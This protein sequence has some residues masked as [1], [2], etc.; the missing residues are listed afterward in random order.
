[1]ASLKYRER[2][3][4]VGFLGS[5]DCIAESEIRWEALTLLVLLELDVFHPRNLRRC[6]GR[7]IQQPS[8]AVDRNEKV[9]IPQL[10]F[11]RYRGEFGPDPLSELDQS[12]LET[13]DKSEQEMSSFFVLQKTGI[14]PP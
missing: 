2:L 8:H 3:Y 7:T 13:V 6:Q 4:N 9:L 10:C 11:P 14:D 5:S 1:M 12:N